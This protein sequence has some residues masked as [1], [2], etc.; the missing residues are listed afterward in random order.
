MSLSRFG[1]DRSRLVQ[2][3]DWIRSICDRT[4]RSVVYVGRQQK[5]LKDNSWMTWSSDRC[6][7]ICNCRRWRR[8][9]TPGDVAQGTIISC[10]QPSNRMRDRWVSER[11]NEWMNEWMNIQDNLPEHAAKIFT[12]LINRALSTDLQFYSS[13]SIYWHA[14]SV[15]SV[16]RITSVSYTHLTLPTIYSV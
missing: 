5:K 15:S 8:T 6:W 10:C 14:E 2:L 16:F 11:M 7:S 12:D 9:E 13:F 4:V 1:S 3:P